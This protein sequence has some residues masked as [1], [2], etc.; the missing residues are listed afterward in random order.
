M[1]VTSSSDGHGPDQPSFLGVQVQTLRLG[2][3]HLGSTG[4]VQA[5]G[6]LVSFCPSLVNLDLRGNGFGDSGA[7]PSERVGVCAHT[8]R[9]IWRNGGGIC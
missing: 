3:C 2:W 1:D 9:L 5:I 8:S 4:S 6:E 7:Q